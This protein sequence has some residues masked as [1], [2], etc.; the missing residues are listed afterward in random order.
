MDICL[1]LGGENVEALLAA[2]GD[3]NPVHRM[4]PA[5]P[6]FDRSAL[7]TNWKNLYLDTDWGQLDC[8]GEISG[9]GGYDD[10]M[11][12]SEEVSVGDA[13]C[14]ILTIDALIRAKEAMGRPKDRE[15]VIQLRAIRERR[16]EG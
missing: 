8:L 5:R 16:G 14:R 11:Q 1:P 12:H 10:V 3:L 7:T 13:S 15:A 9:I 6:P 2:T 4:S